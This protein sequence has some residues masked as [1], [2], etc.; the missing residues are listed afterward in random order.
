MHVLKVKGDIW[1]MINI[2]S[3]H[4]ANCHKY[5]TGGFSI[6]F[7]ILRGLCWPG[8]D[9]DNDEEEEEDGSGFID[10]VAATAACPTKWVVAEAG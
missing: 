6:L 8:D 4:L 5:N 3:D 7:V 2:K 10:L 1:Y 9:D